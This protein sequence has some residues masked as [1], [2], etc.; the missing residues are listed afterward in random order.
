MTI[1]KKIENEYNK[2]K[3]KKGFTMKWREWRE[4][5]EACEG[6]PYDSSRYTFEYGFIKGIRYQKKKERTI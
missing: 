3:D 4:I 5:V 6:R 1:L 2:L